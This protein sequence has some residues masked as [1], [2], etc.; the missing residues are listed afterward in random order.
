[1]AVEVVAP[2]VEALIGVVALIAE[3]F[4]RLFASC[5]RSLRYAFSPSYRDTVNERLRVRGPLY[6]AA[7]A[8]W[9]VVAVATCLAAVAAIIYWIAMPEPTPACSKIEL[10]QLAECAQVLRQALQQ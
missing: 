9:G 7:Y 8:S 10:R 6:R 3:W 2:L 5:V 1:M 4:L